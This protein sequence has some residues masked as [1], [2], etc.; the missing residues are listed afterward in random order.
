MRSLCK[1]VAGLVRHGFARMNAETE[2]PSYSCAR[3]SGLKPGLYPAWVGT[4]E[5]VPFPNHVLMRQSCAGDFA[6]SVL[7]G[8]LL[9]QFFDRLTRRGLES[10]GLADQGG[11]GFGP[12]GLQAD[13][14]VAGDETSG[15]FQ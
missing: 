3:P 14:T 10:F 13:Q 8:V 2:K 11:S 4:T 1:R 9:F 15:N 7:E 5:V 12:L 6:L